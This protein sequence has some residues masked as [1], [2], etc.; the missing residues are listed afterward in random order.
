MASF[1]LASSSNFQK[2]P[3]YLLGFENPFLPSPKVLRSLGI[4]GIH[5]IHAGFI[6][7]HD[8]PI[9]FWKQIKLAWL[10]IHFRLVV[11]FQ[12]AYFHSLQILWKGKF[13]KRS[14]LYF[15]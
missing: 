12:S 13:Q 7:R 8:N 15:R 6:A 11:D 14:I 4:P 3:P 2:L 1:L 9:F 5:H 10:Q